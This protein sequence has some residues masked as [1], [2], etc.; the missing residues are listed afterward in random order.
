[1]WD[2]HRVAAR[3]ACV[4]LDLELRSYGSRG[5]QK[6]AIQL[7]SRTEVSQMTSCLRRDV[8]CG[9]SVALEEPGQSLL[10]NCVEG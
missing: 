4:C 5:A 10:C 7:T 3:L 2:S 6:I 1:V 9:C 8:V